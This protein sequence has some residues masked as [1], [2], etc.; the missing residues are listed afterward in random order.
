MLAGSG[1]DV[2]SEYSPGFR[3]ALTALGDERYT[4]NLINTRASDGRG[5][6]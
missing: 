1:P 6:R 4:T 5:N 2:L 3:V